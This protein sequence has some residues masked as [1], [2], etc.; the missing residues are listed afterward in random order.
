MKYRGNIL[1][2]P[3]NWGLGHASRCIPIIKLLLKYKFNP[4]IASDGEALQLLVQEFPELNRI[5][6]PSYN[7]SYSK[8]KHL[9]K[10]K[11]LIDSPKILKAIK[12]EKKMTSEIVKANNIIGIISD[13]RPGVFNKKIPSVF[14]THQLKVMSGSTTWLTTSWHQKMIKHFDQCWVP[15][16]KGPMSLSGELSSL[17]IPKI[18][19]KFIGTLSRFDRII[20]E[21][22]I[23]ILILLSGPE[24]QRSMLEKKLTNSFKETTKTVVMVRGVI[25]NESSTEQRGNMKVYNF[26][27]A[28]HLETLINESAIVISRSGYTSVMDFA[29]L[30]KNVF[31][32]PTPGQFEQQYLAQHLE[33]LRMA[34]FCQQEDFTIDKLEWLKDYEGVRELDY[35]YNFKK[36]FSLFEGE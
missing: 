19:T 32:I 6:L 26:M 10:F 11:M 12:A 30:K 17:E 13:N 2:A 36:L 25:E 31:F 9:L 35:Q 8:N 14:I 28:E 27:L 22:T 21:E 24:P 5:E 16:Y 15:D 20:C 7:I 23:D 29:R 33:E 4:I 18:K 3:L 34:P 1:V